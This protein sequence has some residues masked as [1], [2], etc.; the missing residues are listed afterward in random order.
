MV[1]FIIAHKNKQCVLLCYIY[2][3]LSLCEISALYGRRIECEVAIEYVSIR[4]RSWCADGPGVSVHRYI[5][6]M[7]RRLGVS[8][9]SLQ[10]RCENYLIIVWRCGTILLS[11]ARVSESGTIFRVLLLGIYIYQ[12]SIACVV[13]VGKRKQHSVSTI[14]K[15]ICFFLF[16]VCQSQYVIKQAKHIYCIKC[17]IA[18]THKK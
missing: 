3:Y 16:S 8:N 13:L 4:S 7:C 14:T 6:Q 11:R 5:Q 1:I 9:K 15:L 18:K 12:P 2:I 10:S 17:L